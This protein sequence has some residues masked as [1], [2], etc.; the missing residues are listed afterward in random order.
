MQR[1]TISLDDHLAAAFDSWVAAHGYD[2][3]S[4][5]VRDLLRAEL[6]RQRQASGSSAHCVASLSYVYN[7]H[8]RD[9]GERMT[10]L[11]HAHHA[12]HVA[13]MHVHLDHDHCLEATVLRRETAAVQAFADAARAERGVRHGMLNL[14]S[15]HI[16]ADIGAGMAHPH[17]GGHAAHVHI[18]PAD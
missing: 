9:L 8:E 3:R 10:A 6:E 15:A 12:V 17:G 18:T 4:E 13:T 16:D 7:H 2:N 1:F 5:A 11:Q 14:I